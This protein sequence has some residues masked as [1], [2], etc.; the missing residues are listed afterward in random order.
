MHALALLAVIIFHCLPF[1]LHL[2]PSTIYDTDIHSSHAF[3]PF[4]IFL[5][6]L[7]LH[8]ITTSFPRYQ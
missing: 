3:T 2:P 7:H 8:D 6:R 1:T 5:L 4:L